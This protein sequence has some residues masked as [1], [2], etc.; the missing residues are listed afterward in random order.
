MSYLV[1]RE[2]HDGTGATAVATLRPLKWPTGPAQ[3]WKAAAGPREVQAVQ[4]PVQGQCKETTR[5][6]EALHRGVLVKPKSSKET[7]ALGQ[8]GHCLKR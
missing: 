2:V 7:L 8:N 3:A 6:E 1:A 4:Q 5:K